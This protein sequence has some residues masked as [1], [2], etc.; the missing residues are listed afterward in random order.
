MPDYITTSQAAEL[1]NTTDRTIRRRLSDMSVKCP[2]LVRY[3]RKQ[4]KSILIYKNLVLGNF[5]RIVDPEPQETIQE[6]TTEQTANADFSPNEFIEFLKEQIKQKDK[7]IEELQERNREQNII[8][9]T[10]Q[11]NLSLTQG[12][13]GTNNSTGTARSK[14]KIEYLILAILAAV[15][16][17]LILI[18]TDAA[19]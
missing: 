16:L 15:L 3:V 7:Q 10:A 18:Y 9:Q 2:H 19:L 6:Q 13:T 1:L 14:F 12:T 11:Q 5:E 4:G 8:I 17:F